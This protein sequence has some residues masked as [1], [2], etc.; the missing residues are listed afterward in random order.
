MA[1][2]SSV[3]AWR[4]PGTGEL[5]ELPSTG[6]HRVRHNWSNLA[7]AKRKPVIIAINKHVKNNCYE[8]NAIKFCLSVMAS[9]RLPAWDWFC[10]FIYTPA[11][12]AFPGLWGLKERVNFLLWDSMSTLYL[13]CK[14]CIQGNAVL[15]FLV[16]VLLCKARRVSWGLLVSLSQGPSILSLRAF[17]FSLTVLLSFLG[18]WGKMEQEQAGGV[19]NTEKHRTMTSLLHTSNNATPN[20][21]IQ[22]ACYHLTELVC[23]NGCD[24][25]QN[26]EKGTEWMEWV[27]IDDKNEVGIWAQGKWCAG[28]ECKLV[29]LWAD[30]GLQKC[31]FLGPH[32]I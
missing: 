19:P 20:P 5:G 26:H 28:W 8:N 15:M 29:Y 1:T 18:G 10:W 2:H 25:E 12:E 13:S 6:S 4:I 14:S 21:I 3:L 24:W 11:K 22:R 30:S 27:S 23:A 31:I 7:A 32:N 9:W 17:P 16:S